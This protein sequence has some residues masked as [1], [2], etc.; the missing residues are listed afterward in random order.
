MRWVGIFAAFDCIFRPSYLVLGSITVP[1]NNQCA[2]RIGVDTIFISF[3]D[4]IW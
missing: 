3:E 1:S 4:A 2:A